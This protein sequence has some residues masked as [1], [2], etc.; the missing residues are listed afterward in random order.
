MNLSAYDK[1][2]LKINKN[3]TW[4]H[5]GVLISREIEYRPY[6]SFVT[7]FDKDLG[8]RYYLVLMDGSPIDI[9]TMRTRR[10]DYNRLKFITNSIAKESGLLNYSDAN[11]PIKLI[12]KQEDC[13]IYLIDI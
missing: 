10:D 9:Q 11:V 7:R 1:I 5:K 12:E 4:L 6:Y 3:L 13:T 8:V 2:H